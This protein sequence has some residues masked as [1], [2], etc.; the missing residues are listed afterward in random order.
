MHTVRLPW[1]GFRREEHPEA[2][3]DVTMQAKN[4]L[5][6]LD[7]VISKRCTL[8]AIMQKKSKHTTFN[9]E[10]LFVALWGPVPMEFLTGPRSARFSTA[11]PLLTLPIH[12]PN[13]G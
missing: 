1:S 6:N 8:P 2:P 10:N 9:F 12:L 3:L 11:V 13:G 7:C 5:S 4:V